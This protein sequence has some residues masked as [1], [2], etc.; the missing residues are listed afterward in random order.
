MENGLNAQIT[1]ADL[2]CAQAIRTPEG[3]RVDCK[4]RFGGD[5]QLA[6]F[7][8]KPK[9]ETA[10]HLQ[11]RIKINAQATAAER[12]GA[13]A[14]RLSL[15]LTSDGEAAPSAQDRCVEKDDQ[16]TEGE[17]SRRRRWLYRV[18]SGPN[19]QPWVVRPVLH[20][21]RCGYYQR[22]E[23]ELRGDAEK[24]VAERLALRVPKGAE[25]TG[26]AKKDGYHVTV[27]VGGTVWVD[28]VVRFSR[29]GS[30]ATVTETMSCHESA[31]DKTPKNVRPCARLIWTV[32]GDAITDLSRKT[33]ER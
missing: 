25:R 28:R 6:L 17:R 31:L 18:L 24:R 29:R 32:D 33:I 22:R 26:L 5:D 8:L 20:W 12:A 3:S 23:G 13:E 4:D 1:R 10:R 27:K 16:L 7:R 14:F 21:T 2:K 9:G 11:I 15:D 19:S 30:K